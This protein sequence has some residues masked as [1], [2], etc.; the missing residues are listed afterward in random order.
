L[1]EG[2]WIGQS[3]VIQI[4]EM[5]HTFD[6]RLYMW[7]EITSR[8]TVQERSALLYY[9]TDHDTYELYVFDS[10]VSVPLE[11]MIFKYTSKIATER[12][13]KCSNGGYVMRLGFALGENNSQTVQLQRE[14]CSKQ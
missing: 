1:I 6:N 14:T 11:I 3:V 8:N 4:E 7:V 2:V 9:N 10:G 12:R 5:N 13:M